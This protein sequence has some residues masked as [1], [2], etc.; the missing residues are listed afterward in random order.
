MI[1]GLRLLVMMGFIG[2]NVSLAY[3]AGGLQVL[4]KDINGDG[5]LEIAI[6]VYVDDSIRADIYVWDAQGNL[7]SGWPFTIYGTEM[8][9]HDGTVALADF[10]KD[11]DDEIVA[12]SYDKGTHRLR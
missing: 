3:A 1:R 5:E 11:G 8:Y 12:T 6:S 10:D 7:L 4:Q 9:L 2:T